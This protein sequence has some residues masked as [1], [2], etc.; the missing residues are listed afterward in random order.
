MGGKGTM[1]Q[2][3]I[4]LISIVAKVTNV[5]VTN[6]RHYILV[7]LFHANINQVGHGP[8]GELHCVAVEGA[9]D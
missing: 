2:Y 8:I 4:G 3:V 5:H 7:T 1:H 6:G 9:V